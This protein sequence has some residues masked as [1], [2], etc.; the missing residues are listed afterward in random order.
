MPEENMQNRKKIS[1]L[2]EPTFG[3]AHPDDDM[4]Q[5]YADGAVNH[6]AHLQISAHLQSCVVCAATIA[7]YESLNDVL[8]HTPVIEPS[9]EFDAR[10]AEGIAA[11]FRDKRRS[12]FAAL[13]GNY[14]AWLAAASIIIVLAAAAI[15]GSGSGS[16]KQPTGITTLITGQITT[17]LSETTSAFRDA[18]PIK[19]IG[20]YLLLLLSL[21]GLGAFDRILRQRLL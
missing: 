2:H 10:M 3:G 4:L 13:K 8:R 19:S 5:M 6:A 12:R 1:K 9:S 16:I 7:Q 21:A 14:I 15:V 20:G 18:S 17:I 11:A